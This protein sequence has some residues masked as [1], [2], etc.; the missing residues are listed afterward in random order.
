MAAAK[1]ANT[2]R[3]KAFNESDREVKELFRKLNRMHIA[4]LNVKERRALL[5]KAVK[6]IIKAAKDAAPIDK[7]NLKNSI[8][9]L[10][11]MK[12]IN[13]VYVGPRYVGRGS[14]SDKAS[15]G[16]HAH[17]SEYGTRFGNQKDKGWFRRAVNASRD[18]ALNELRRLINDQFEKFKR[19]YGF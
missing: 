7:G 13:A 3:A 1:S 5:K 10:T 17:F 4:Y 11:H 12:D 2:M 19:R 8:K 14:K 15:A 18:Q 16:N 6:P 9:M